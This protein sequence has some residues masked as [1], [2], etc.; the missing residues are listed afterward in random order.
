MQKD[1]QYNYNVIR[2]IIHNKVLCQ[3]GHLSYQSRYQLVEQ[4]L[5]FIYEA[6]KEYDPEKH[7]TGHKDNFI[8]QRCFWRWLDSEK[9]KKRNILK[10]KSIVDGIKS[11]YSTEYGFYNEEEIRKDLDKMNI[12]TDSYME[13]AGFKNI[14]ID[15]VMSKKDSKSFVLNDKNLANIEWEDF[16]LNMIKKV[17]EFFDITNKSTKFYKL[18]I[19]DHLIPKCSGEE[20]KTTKQISEELHLSEGMISHILHSKRMKNFIGYCY[21]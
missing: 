5:S 8:A 4:I 2:V 11:R 14:S 10:E 1:N 12:D 7:S 19:K 9:S 15:S 6:E 3:F 21:S 16:K 13:S 20:Y 17:D 18:V